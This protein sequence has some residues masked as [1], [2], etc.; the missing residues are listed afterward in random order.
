MHYIFCQTEKVKKKK[1]S[2]PLYTLFLKKQLAPRGLFLPALLFTP[3]EKWGRCKCILVNGGQ[4]MNIYPFHAEFYFSSVFFYPSIT[5]HSHYYYKMKTLWGISASACTPSPS[6]H[7]GT[8]RYRLL[9]GDPNSWQT[10]RYGYRVGGT[11][12][13]RSV[14]KLKHSSSKDSDLKPCVAHKLSS[15]SKNIGQI[16]NRSF[17][18]RGWRV[19][20]R[21]KFRNK[22]LSGT[23]AKRSL[24]YAQKYL[25]HVTYLTLN[26]FLPFLCSLELWCWNSWLLHH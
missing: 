17:G 24:M 16:G 23:F 19:S 9:Y 21:R 22:D 5:T 10:M 25:P 18:E 11:G 7:W 1:K 15:R 20:F 4:M 13:D 8:H 26:F 2:H 3:K 14:C 6:Q 12:E